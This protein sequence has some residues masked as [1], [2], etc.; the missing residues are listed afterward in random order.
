MALPSDEPSPPTRPIEVEREQ[1]ESVKD[2]L[3]IQRI[4][5]EPSQTR[6]DQPGTAWLAF[7]GFVILVDC[8][9]QYPEA[10]P[11]VRLQVEQEPPEAVTVPWQSGARLTD[12]VV[13]AAMQA[14]A[15]IDSSMSGGADGR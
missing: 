9:E 7:E 1:L 8:S 11:N 13:A 15:T 6:P 12:A 4:N 14:R 10:A 3:G 2:V 5:L